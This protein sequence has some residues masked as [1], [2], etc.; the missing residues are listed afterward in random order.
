M[1]YIIVAAIAVMLIFI[2]HASFDARLASRALPVLMAAF[3][4]RLAIHVLVMRSSIIQYGGDNLYYEVR[5]MGIAEYWRHEGIQFVG[6]EQV[7]S[8][9]SVSVPCHVFAAIIYLCGERAP[10]ACTA[11]VALIACGLCIVMYKFAR[12][13]G[14]DERAAFRLLVIT[15][16]VP[17]FMLHT[18][19]TFKDGFN[20][21]LVLACLGLAASNMQR[22]DMRKLFFLGPLLWMLWHVR[23]YMVFMCALP[24]LFGV[25]RIKRALSVRTI[26]V[27]AALLI[28][29]LIFFQGVDEIAPVMALQEQLQRG[30][31]SNVRLANA[32]G[33]SGVV[34]EDG[35]SAWNALGPKIIYTILSPFPWMNGSLALQLGKIDTLLWYYLLYCAAYGIRRL[36]CYDRRM[37]LIILLFVVPGTIAYATTVSNIGLIFRQRMPIMMV[38]SL[39]AAIAWTKT[40]RKGEQPVAALADA[41]ASSV[42]GSR[43]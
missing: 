25:A 24:L 40:L 22:F 1:E 33:G 41:T 5:A 9:Y 4:V 26:I 29:V 20:A 8:I 23:P 28:P 11:I 2:V 42:S 18:S 14:A 19:D 15:A 10:L 16:F 38:T 13:V 12:L 32:E 21:F 27:F 43:K 39:L 35:G 37:M 7:D 30:Q 36:W 3:V 17:G 34:F 6:P 31:S